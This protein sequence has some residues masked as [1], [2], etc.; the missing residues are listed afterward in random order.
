Y[1]LLSYKDDV[2]LE[3]KLDEWEHFYNFNRPHGAF[4]GQTPYEAL[5]E[6]L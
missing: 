3:A 4:N 6:R 1:Q 2:D 5:R